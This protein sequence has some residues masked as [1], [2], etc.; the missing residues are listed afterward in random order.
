VHILC[1][2]SDCVAD[3]VDFLNAEYVRTVSM[4]YR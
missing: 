2:K 4:D 3:T 1:L